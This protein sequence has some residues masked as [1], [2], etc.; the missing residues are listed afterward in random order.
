MLQ[1]VWPGRQD[2]RSRMALKSGP[3]GYPPC[4]QEPAEGVM[5]CREG[6]HQPCIQPEGQLPG[7]GGRTVSPSQTWHSHGPAAGWKRRA[8]RAHH[9]LQHRGLAHA[10]TGQET[11]EPTPGKWFHRLFLYPPFNL[12]FGSQS[13]S[14]VWYCFLRF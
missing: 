8:G 5:P 2:T 4:G 3:V 1:V 11:K 13:C 6:R 12:V 9:R 10:C 14:S 7:Y